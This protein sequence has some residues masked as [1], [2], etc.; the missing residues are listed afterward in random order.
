MATVERYDG[1]EGS[2]LGLSSCGMCLFYAG[3]GLE[4][5][6]YPV[7][8]PDPVAYITSGAAIAYWGVKA[9]IA[10]RIDSDRRQRT[11]DQIDAKALEDVDRTKNPGAPGF[12]SVRDWQ[13]LIA[14]TD[15]IVKASIS[16]L[17]VQLANDRIEDRDDIKNWINGSFM[18]AGVVEAKLEAIADRLDHIERS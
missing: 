12:I 2:T 10:Q 8:L 6:T 13:I 11:K 4:L 5:S 3:T 17:R 16:D 1:V 14:E 9:F 15:K 18:R 7:N